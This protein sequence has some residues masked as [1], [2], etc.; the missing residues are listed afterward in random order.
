MTCRI[1]KIENGKELHMD[2]VGNFVPTC[3]GCDCENPCVLKHEHLDF[4]TD[5]NASTFI[6]DKGIEDVFIRNLKNNQ[7]IDV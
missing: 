7:R 1:A 2:E 3:N 5:I 6:Q 4:R